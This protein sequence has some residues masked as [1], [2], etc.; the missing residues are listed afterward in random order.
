MAVSSE[1]SITMIGKKYMA[2]HITALLNIITLGTFWFVCRMNASIE[3]LLK[4]R[5]SELSEADSVVVEDVN[6]EKRIHFVE[7]IPATG[8]LRLKRYIIKGHVTVVDTTYGRFVYDWLQN[9]YVLPVYSVKKTEINEIFRRRLEMGREE[10]AETRERALLYGKNTCGPEAASVG[11]VVCREIVNVVFVWQAVPICL[12]IAMRYYWYALFVGSIFIWLFVE[13]VVDKVRQETELKAMSRQARIK[14]LRKGEFT[15]VWEEEV[16]PGDVVAVEPCDTFK[17]DAQILQGDVVVDESFLTGESVSICKGAGSSVYAGTKVLRSEAPEAVAELKAKLK[18]TMRQF[19]VEP[20]IEL[21]TEQKITPETQQKTEVSPRSE[22]NAKTHQSTEINPSSEPSTST[23]MQKLMRVKNLFG[24][25]S[26]H[27]AHP[28]ALGVVTKTGRQTRRGILFRN[29]L[30]QK[31]VADGYGAQSGTIMRWLFGV[32]LVISVVCGLE[33]A[34]GVGIFNGVIYAMDV[35]LAMFNPALYFC[36]ELANQRAKQQLVAKGINTVDARRINRA[37]E[38]DTVVFDKTGTLTQ[39]DVDIRWFDTFTGT[40][41]KLEQL[42]SLERLAFSTCHS[43]LELDG[44]YSGDVLDMKMLCMS[45]AGV[46]NKKGKRCI[47]LASIQYVPLCREENDGFLFYDSNCSVNSNQNIA[48]SSDDLNSFIDNTAI[49]NDVTL[50]QIDKTIETETIHNTA[51][52]DVTEDKT[53]KV[54]ILHIYDFDSKLKRMSVVVAEPSLLFCKGAPDALAPICNNLPSNFHE[55][56]N[57]YA[58]QGYRVLALAYRSLTK[59]TNRS[60]DESGLQLLGLV[61]FANQLKAEARPTVET[62]GSA[63]LATKMCTGDNILT[64]ICVARECAM[65]GLDTPVLFP[66]AEE[67][68]LRPE[69]VQWY[70]VADDDYIFDR[71][72]R[73]LY[74]EFDNAESDFIV[75]CE[76]REYDFLKRH[77]QE[78]FILDK[79]VVFA[80]FDPE[81]KKALIEDYSRIGRTVLFCGDGANDTGALAAAD[82]GL[83]LA[84]SEAS[85]AAPF[86]SPRLA[87]VVSLICEARRALAMSIVQFKY[88]LFVQLLTGGQMVAL[89]LFRC[90][91]SDLMSLFADCVGFFLLSYAISNSKSS[92]VFAVRPHCVTLLQDS[93][94]I[95]MECF[96]LFLGFVL[97]LFILERPTDRGVISFAMPHTTILFFVSLFL[98]LLKSFFYT[99]CTP[100]REWRSRNHYFIVVYLFSLFLVIG[101]V[102]FYFSGNLAIINNFQF[103]VLDAKDKRLFLIFSGVVSFLTLLWNIYIDRKKLGNYASQS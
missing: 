66:V 84:R 64:A 85:L 36:Q 56:V 90:F 74:S 91:F 79:G 37:G 12:W 33:L 34:S 78:Q 41:E 80:R 47:E 43:V 2:P 8:S 24:S 30:T 15:E 42:S 55:R 49:D 65:V 16:Y 17:C 53:R 23:A 87:S 26:N 57:E 61:V 45:Q 70:C 52:N 68:V 72:R 97:F 46:V 96:I 38:I 58:L 62:L 4:T 99:D 7:R 54:E 103:A 92:R 60:A 39:L 73:T 50:E 28:W 29:L 1:K 13:N 86:N 6:G 69:D 76:G 95:A 11:E 18:T 77:G 63:G 14:V 98:C 19:N 102:F 9:K 20:K 67:G 31:Q 51:D 101:L 5:N 82:V 75:A 32:T 94:R 71:V 40:K 100:H 83:S 27:L 59:L 21:K 35:A 22:Q 88:S 89:L 48:T 81:N 93:I 44:K 10:G 3:I 25:H